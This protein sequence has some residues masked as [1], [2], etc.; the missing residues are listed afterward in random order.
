M[1]YFRIE[2]SLHKLRRWCALSAMV[3]AG[4]GSLNAQ[5]EPGD[6]VA[7]CGDS[8]TQQ[9]L[10]SVMME[11]YLLMC[12]PQQDLNAVQF[13]WGGEQVS[14]LVK[15]MENDVLPFKPTVATTCYG[16][17]D[18]RY[19]PVDQG[20]LD[21]YREN[22]AKMVQGFKK[23]G[24]RFI[25]VGSPGVVDPER[26]KRS[27][28][29][30]AEYNETL[31]EL[32]RVAQE[33]AESEGVAFAD[34]YTPMMEGMIRAKEK[35]GDDFLVAA[36]GVHPGENGHLLMAYAFLKALGCDGDI[37]TITVNYEAE[38]ARTDTSQK[39]L[40]FEEGELTIESTRYPF[41]FSTRN[42]QRGAD[43]MSEFIPF[44]EELNRYQLIV[45]NA[46]PMT[47]ITWG[48]MS[49]NYTAEELAAGINLAADFSTS[50][51]STPFREVSAKV[52]TQQRF[53]ETAIKSLLHSLISWRNLFPEEDETFLMLQTRVIEKDDEFR[54]AA[55]EAVVPVRHSIRITPAG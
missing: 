45:E 23:A 10:Y 14:G 11:E 20:V 49:R 19:R 25:V 44:N 36:D 22:T 46:P 27:N 13:G 50:P 34:V 52:K 51:F 2:S 21:S 43:T 42:D 38:T 53:E 16:M 30:A 55:R 35:Y 8:I 32:S 18:G 9:K 39:V 7:I 1:K 3:A 29:S 47:T 17:N 54:R 33:V 48:E 28:S 5:L 4:C 26:Y 40:A 6:L 24:V 41:C 12:Q 31:K 15:R 37:G